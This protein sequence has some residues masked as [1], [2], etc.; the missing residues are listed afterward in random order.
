MGVGFGGLVAEA[1]EIR[2]VTWNVQNGVGVEGSASFRAVRETLERLD[3]DVIA[4]QEV[5]VEEAS[6][7]A[8]RHF[9]DLRALLTGLGFATTRTYL[10]TAGDG[11]QAQA[12][13]AGDFGH[14]GQSV[15]VASRFPITRTVQIGRGVAGR[16]EQTR[17]PLYVR[18]AVPGVTGG[19]ALVNVHF[20]QGDAR[21]DEFRRGVEAWRVRE[22]LMA[23]SV[24]GR[25]GHVLVVGDVN[26]EI[27]EPQSESFLTA[28]V[29]GGS[30]FGDGSGMP[31]GYTGGADW[32]AVLP[33]AVFPASAF[34]SLGVAVVPA[35][36]TDGVSDRTYH[37]AGDA[38]LDY[39]L[40]GAFTR[41]AGAVRAEVYHSG[42]ESVGDGLPKR[43]AL[44]DPVL[45]LV[46]SDH[47]PVVADC[48][49]VP[50]PALE[51]SVPAAVVAAG[52]SLDGPEV[53]GTVS[54]P[55]V[56]DRAV[57][58]TLAP[59]REAPL[60][61]IPPVVIPA[62]EVSARFSLV[63]RGSPF[64]SD[65]RFTL[66]ATADGYRSG[67]ASVS[68]RGGGGA[69]G[70]VLISQYT[71]TPGG[72][73][74][75]AVEIIN[76]SA[77]EIF[78]AAEPLRLLSFSSGAVAGVQEVLAEA[79][80]LPVGA[81]V[82]IG[83]ATTG[84][85]LVADGLLR[86]TDAALAGALTGTVFTDTGAPD[87]RAIFIKRGFSFNGDDALEV[88]INGAR[89]DVFGLIGH[90]PGTA[91]TGSGVST[92]NQN[93]SRRRTVFS[94]SAGWIDPSQTFEVAGVS[95]ATALSGMGVAPVLDD[96]Y[97]M[98]AAER[99]LVGTAAAFDADPDDNG[100]ANGLEFVFA[101]PL[102]ILAL[103]RR[104]DGEAGPPSMALQVRHRLG[105]VRWGVAVADD[106]RRWHP[107]A[108]H[109]AVVLPRTEDFR[110]VAVPWP[111]SSGPAG[112][113]RLFVIKP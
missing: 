67:L 77:R 82:V 9:A 21:A 39:I 47:L 37:W 48:Q 109:G 108:E 35:R 29:A 18:L 97:A 84:R 63:V 44:P 87:G 42:R 10:A 22:F 91:W 78:F 56:R 6:P 4:L 41:A 104:V 14:G 113:A 19:V 72:S 101:R 31:A 92:A 55:A 71:E 5:D 68:T 1:V 90:D 105:N 85:A 32:P 60:L 8:A 93:L 36:Q 2:V 33:Y 75:K 7:S 83:D 66:V 34:E 111:S 23:E 73:S 100:V 13:V 54:L 25:T 110:N 46:A 88:R 74:P 50:T 79:G 53:V 80:R 43:T 28:G 51:M 12:Y 95:L 94:P 59:W 102:E 57:T 107:V 112:Q 58:V 20:K 70:R 86:A 62:G 26:E 17:F 98:W 61:P 3:P 30:F 52:F 40:A 81:V 15:V 106:L 27:N 99:G 69:D 11:F 89:S 76:V 49:L 65:R 45:S 38:R 16:R 24:D 64:G 96:P 103:Q